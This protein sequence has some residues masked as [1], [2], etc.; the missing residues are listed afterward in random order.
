MPSEDRTKL[1]LE[2]IGPRKEQFLSAIAATTEEIRALLSGTGETPQDQTEAL[3]KFARGH[4]DV[5]RFSAFTRQAARIE[6]DAEKPVRAAQDVL[7]KLL[8][9]GEALFV[10]KLESG[11]DLGEAVA[12]RL[13]VIGLA[14]AAAHL[15][16]LAKRG[17]YREEEHAA[18]LDGFAYR[19][20]SRAE[21]KLAPGLVVELD[22]ADFTPATVAPYLD[23]GMKM[24]FVVDG[25][26][27]VAAMARL[28]T[29]GAFVQQTDGEELDAFTAFVARN[30]NM[31]GKKTA[32][33]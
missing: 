24:V 2:A 3:G 17:N 33:A 27:P 15:T 31:N 28:V 25:D 19:D 1:A 12:H 7:G 22:G 20:W 21:R 14:F 29:P 8:K 26:A 9:E 6:G 4:V 32:Y 5:E 18:M 11:S 13:S 30:W 23:A 10:L 16:D